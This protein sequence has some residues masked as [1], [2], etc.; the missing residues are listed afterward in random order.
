MSISALFALVPILVD[1]LSIVTSH[2]SVPGEELF[3][4]GGGGRGKGGRGGGGG[5][6][7]LSII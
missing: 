1:K 5:G 3:H 7:T 6:E 2:L 4:R